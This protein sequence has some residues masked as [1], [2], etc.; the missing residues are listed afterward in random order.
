MIVHIIFTFDFA[1][2][3]LNFM[4]SCALAYLLLARK[5]ILFTLDLPL[6]VELHWTTYS[7]SLKQPAYF[8][9]YCQQLCLFSKTNVSNLI[10][11][12]EICHL[13]HLP[14]F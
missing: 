5:M 4:F 9:L 1:F 7:K 6:T 14:T 12:S 11:F 10:Y 3:T 13:W 8:E 2:G